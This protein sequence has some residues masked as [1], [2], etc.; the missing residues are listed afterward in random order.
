MHLAV[1]LTVGAVGKGASKKAKKEQRKRFSAVLASVAESLL[2]RGYAVC[3]NFVPKHLIEGVRGEIAQMQSHY[4]PG[5]IWVGK[6]ADV[7]AQISARSV[8]GDAVLWMD[9]QA[10]SATAFVKDGAKRKCSFRTL[11][12]VVKSLD[13]LVMGELRD[14]VPPLKRLHKRSDAMLA[15]YPGDGARFARHI[16]N[17]ATDGRHLTVLCYLNPTWDYPANGG[18]LRIFPADGVSPPVDVAPMGG[19]VA[20]FYSHLVPHEVLACHAPRHAVTVW[21]YDAHEHAEAMASAKMPGVGASSPAA[22]REAR[23]IIRDILSDV[24][25]PTPEAC[26]LLAVRVASTSAAAL[27]ILAGVTGAPSGDALAAAIRRLDPE[28]LVMLRESLGN[29]GL[30]AATHAPLVK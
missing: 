16:D 22:Q 24:D 15:I 6:T 13:R 28:G 1:A 23:D 12:Q 21:Y 19:R 11:G 30:A 4:T 2:A 29:M 18:A 10:L 5:E 14:R 27:G 17:T 3:D 20:M 25:E 8:R 7:G 26:R 9:N